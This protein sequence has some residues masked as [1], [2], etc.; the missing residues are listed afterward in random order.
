MKRP[1]R[2][3]RVARSS[4]TGHFALLHGR[5]QGFNMRTHAKR[6]SAVGRWLT[7]AG[8][9]GTFSLFQQTGC[10]V[11]PD[12]LLPTFLQVVGDIALFTL[13]NAIYT[14]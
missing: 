10:G 11:D 4:T 2:Y 8:L 1:F 13:Q 14:F 3:R 9:A 6:A 12:I 7:L 5:Q